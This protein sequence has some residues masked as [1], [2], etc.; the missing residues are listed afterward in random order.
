MPYDYLVLATGVNAAFFGVDGAE[1]HS[2]SLYTRQD[3]IV[4]RNQLMRDRQKREAEEA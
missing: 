1:K 3:A 4:L 2:F